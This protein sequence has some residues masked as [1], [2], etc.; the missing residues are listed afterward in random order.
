METERSILVTVIQRMFLKFPQQTRSEMYSAVSQLEELGNSD[1]LQQ[2]QD[3][4]IG[5]SNAKPHQSILEQARKV[6]SSIDK[7]ASQE[8]SESPPFETSRTLGR[9]PSYGDPRCFSIEDNKL[10][11]QDMNTFAGELSC[12]NIKRVQKNVAGHTTEQIGP[13]AEGS[14]I[15]SHGSHPQAPSRMPNQ[16]VN[17]KNPMRNGICGDWASDVPHKPRFPLF[18][19]AGMRAMDIPIANRNMMSQ[20]GGFQSERPFSPKIELIKQVADFPAYPAR[21]SHFPNQQAM[22]STQ[23]LRPMLAPQHSGLSRGA[24]SSVWDTHSRGGK[25]QWSQGSP[26]QWSHAQTL[27]SKEIDFTRKSTQ[28]GNK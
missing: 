1:T 15:V 13:F 2:F 19:G 17:P 20:Y 24:M 28:P 5:C 23:G 6:M 4:L 22:V 16:F 26:D 14:M 11:E 3:M 9:F 25:L 7:N 8:T 10:I 18:D 27:D 12:R 21:V